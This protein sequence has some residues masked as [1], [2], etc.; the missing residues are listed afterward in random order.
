MKQCNEIC[1]LA[2]PFAVWRYIHGNKTKGKQKQKIPKT[3]NSERALT[4]I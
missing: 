3:K 2:R 1:I 4:V